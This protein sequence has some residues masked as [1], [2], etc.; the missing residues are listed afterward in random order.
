[1]LK[2]CRGNATKLEDLALEAFPNDEKD[3]ALYATTVLLAIAPLAKNADGNVLFPARLHLMFRG[4]QGLFMCSNPNCH[5]K[6]SSELP[7]GK[8]Y[9][10]QKRDTC[11][12]GGK[13]FELL[14]DRS[15]GSL[16]FKGYIDASEVSAK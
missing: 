14:N 11:D 15:C 2:K 12:C 4:L 16:Y 10:S 3:V 9:L 8:V 6:E 13:V 1:M 5:C 7:F